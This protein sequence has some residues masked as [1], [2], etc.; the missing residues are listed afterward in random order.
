MSGLFSLSHGKPRIMSKGEEPRSTT[1]RVVLCRNSG[2]L[3]Q[4]LHAAVM[5]PPRLRD[6]SA[7]L[8]VIGSD[9]CDVVI[10]FSRTKIKLAKLPVAPESTSALTGIERP[11]SGVSIQSDNSNASLPVF[12]APSIRSKQIDLLVLH[13]CIWSAAF[14]R[15]LGPSK[16]PA[17]LS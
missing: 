14:R 9:N 4:R 13:T 15:M 3:I 7:F 2:D 11:V 1:S 17:A 10:S 12:A 8:T 6:P 16:N 5:G